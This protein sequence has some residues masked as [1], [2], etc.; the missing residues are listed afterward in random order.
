MPERWQG[1]CFNC[2]E[3]KGFYCQEPSVSEIR[4]RIRVPLNGEKPEIDHETTVENCSERKA[5]EEEL[6]ELRKVG[7]VPGWVRIGYIKQI[8]SSSSRSNF[9]KASLDKS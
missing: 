3:E 4:G 2:A 1:R 7:I 9:A 6:A 5:K 8:L